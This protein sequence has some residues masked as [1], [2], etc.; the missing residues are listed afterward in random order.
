MNIRDFLD[1][2]KLQELQDNFSDAT[3]LAAVLQDNKGVN[4]TKE[5]NFTDFCMKY[6]HS[7][8][9]GSH[10]CNK[11]NNDNSGVYY[12]H[13][14]LM[15]FSIDIMLGREKVGKGIGGQVL[16]RKP[17]EESFRRIATE[18]GIDSDSYI[19]AIKKVPV[20]NEKNIKAAAELFGQMVN[21]Y[22]NLEYSHN[23]NG[24]KL[25]QLQEEINHATNVIQK[26]NTNTSS[27]K[28]IANKQ[29]MLSLNASIEA[30]RS[31]EA[32]VGFAVVAKSMGEL[33]SQSATIYGDIEKSVIE[34]TDSIEKLASLFENN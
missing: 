9:E 30:A 1:L 24:G 15:A 12:C 34:V 10:R 11:S 20:S 3:G 21:M 8:E 33:S 16:P 25:G 19:N 27:L 2:K 7:S 29:K 5:S 18:L 22:V 32:G 23:S 28:S 13:A 4:I 14:G 6:T 31:G 17:E 26:I